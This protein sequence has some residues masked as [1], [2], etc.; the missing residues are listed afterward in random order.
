MAVISIISSKG[1]AGKTTLAFVLA[2]RLAAG[3]AKVAVVDAD[4][5]QPIADWSTSRGADRPSPFEVLAHPM[6]QME[7]LASAI[8]AADQAN[9]FVIVDVEGT[10]ARVIPAAIVLSN[11][12]LT[13]IQPSGQD[14]KQ[15]A[16]IIQLVADLSDEQDRDIPHSLVFTKVSAAISSRTYKAMAAQLRDAGVSVLPVELIDREAYRAW[17]TYKRTLDEFTLR[18]VSNPKPA[19][20]NADAL[21]RAVLA[22]L[23]GQAADADLQGA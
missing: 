17:F 22:A 10:A 12:V 14:A 4:P 21:T 1:G 9:D 15:A 8:A 23:E 13:P 3:G 18:Q 7:E 20:D 19:I 5:N 16:K 6:P 11:L 2:S